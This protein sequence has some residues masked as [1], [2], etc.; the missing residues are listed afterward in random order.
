MESTVLYNSAQAKNTMLSAPVPQQT[1]TYKPVS[2]RELMD[3][4]LESIYQS[5]F[6]LESQNY[7][8]ARGG[9]IATAR[10]AISNVADNEMKLQIAW[11]NSYDR[12]ASL[13]FAMGVKI[14]VCSNGMVSGDMGSFRKI[15]K[16]DIQT[17][18]PT[19]ITEY[20]KQ[21]GDAFKSI[22]D[23]REIMKTIGV[24]EQGQAELLGRLFIQENLINTKQLNIAKREL[25]TPTHDYGHPN[26][27]W[28]LYNHVTF[29][30][31]ETH[32]TDW[33]RVHLKTH[34][35]FKNCGNPTTENMKADAKMFAAVLKN[36]IDMFPDYEG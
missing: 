16:G 33:M 23:D 30:M 31:K 14:M 15:H 10:Y 20:I 18:T 22:Q 32:P 27:L 29:A 4:T 12:S 2:H 3:L 17:F 34:E 9:N 8:T 5:G 13:K 11:Q 25:S 28:E 35:F 21:G 36:Q 6:T 7:S 26:S 1:K 24:S 19:A